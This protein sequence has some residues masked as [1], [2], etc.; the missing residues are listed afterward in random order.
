MRILQLTPGTGSF[1]CGS[2][3]RDNALVLALRRLGHD[4]A[5]LP[6]YLPPVLE[7]GPSAVVNDRVLFGGVNV[8]LQEHSSLFRALPTSVL[9]LFD[10]RWLLR[11]AGKRAG[12]TEPHELGPLTV[13]MLRGEEG[14]QSREVDRLIDA[15]RAGPKPDLVSLSNALLVGLARRIKRDL[16]VPVICTL[17]GED[18]FLDSLS[19]ADRTLAWSTLA[20][21]AK[22]VDAFV[23]ISHYY[24]QIM[25]SR[26][27]LRDDQFHVVHNG[28]D[29]SP[30]SPPQSPQPH[31][32]VPVI[33]YLSRLCPA[34]GLHTIVDAFIE[35]RRARPDLKPRLHAAGTMTPADVPY[36][37]SLKR[38]LLNAKLH[39]SATFTPNISLHDKVAFLR[40]LKMLSVPANYGEAFGLFV[41]EAM[42]VGVPVVQPRHGA[43]PELI[44][45]TG[46]GI[47]CEPESPVSLAAAIGQLLDDPARARALGQAGQ[48]AVVERF[49]SDAMAQNFALICER[50]FDRFRSSVARS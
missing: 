14:R 6:M 30:Y 35:L 13:S 49:S 40:T 42:A 46:G 37:E 27:S 10:A 4:A 18:S 2:C 50:V 41:I 25:R 43:F 16:N 24:G 22:E 23:A 20:E 34:K 7:E 11:Q 5:M 38:K 9:R 47:L 12:M 32:G 28:I 29:L 3:L 1:H 19:P 26:L 45:A 44:E 31:D 39:D 48:R 17:Q 36:V 21:R 8:Y 33:G 15:L